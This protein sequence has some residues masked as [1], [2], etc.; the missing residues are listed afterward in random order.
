MPLPAYAL[1]ETLPNAIRTRGV[2]QWDVSRCAWLR[3][4]STPSGSATIINDGGPDYLDL[5]FCCS[6][7]CVQVPLDWTGRPAPTTQVEGSRVPDTCLLMGA[8]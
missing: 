3:S 8:E 1:T 6:S 5:L 7:R 2:L 4:I